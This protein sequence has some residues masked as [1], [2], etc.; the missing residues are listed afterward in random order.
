MP[1]DKDK[2]IIAE[3]FDLFAPLLESWL[4]TLT[5]IRNICAHHA[6]LWN[7]ELGIKPASPTQK[8][9]CW[10]SY[11]DKNHPLLAECKKSESQYLYIAV[12]LALSTGGRRMEILGL[13]W[14]DVDFDR[15][16]ITFKEWPYPSV[17]RYVQNEV[18]HEYWGYDGV[19]GEFGE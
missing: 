17:H 5:V 19:Q 8:D 16:I 11:L 14:N 3:G 6:R 10:P 4:H 9:F 15:G 1:K 18:L 2:K 13:S 7:R 12:V